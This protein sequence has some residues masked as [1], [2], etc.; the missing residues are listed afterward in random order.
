MKA[1][2]SERI[3]PNAEVSFWIYEEIKALEERTDALDNFREQFNGLFNTKA[4]EEKLRAIDYIVER[5]KMTEPCSCAKY[6]SCPKC[7]ALAIIAPSAPPPLTKSPPQRDVGGNKL[8]EKCGDP[9][10]E[11]LLYC[12][13]CVKEDDT[14]PTDQAKEE[15]EKRLPPEG[16]A[17]EAFIDGYNLAKERSAELIKDINE[18]LKKW[19]FSEDEGMFSLKKRI[20]ML[21]KKLF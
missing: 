13:A 3:K 19:S 5:F 8:C 4:L 12:N 16:E 14:V 18:E 2:L 9:T 1:R 10:Q 21:S 11:Q 7:N 17:R 15:A 6:R 20:E